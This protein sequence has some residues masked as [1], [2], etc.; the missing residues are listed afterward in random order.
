MSEG[1]AGRIQFLSFHRPALPDGRYSV[2]LT[3]TVWSEAPE[4]SKEIGEQD[5]F[6]HVT[7]GEHPAAQVK[8][9]T[10]TFSI[11]G[12][13][14][15]LDP[16]QIVAVYP[17]EDS[18]GDYADAL[19]HVILGRSTL[20]WEREGQAGREETPWLAV[21]LFDQNEAPTPKVI[22][23]EELYGQ[24]G[25]ASFPTE[26]DMGRN[27]PLEPNEERVTVI[28]VRPELLEKIAP[29]TAELTLLAH[30]RSG[31]VDDR[32]GRVP[33][34]AVVVGN[35]L[36][37]RGRTSVAHL[38][39]VE[40][41]YKNEGLV[42]LDQGK[43]V[44]LV[45]LKSWRYS[46]LDETSYLVTEKAL[47]SLPEPQRSTLRQSNLFNVECVGTKEFKKKAHDILGSDPPGALL[48]AARFKRLTFT[49]LLLK[50]DVGVLRLPALELV[51]LNGTLARR[52]EHYR[53]LGGVPLE[54]QLRGGGVTASWYHGPLISGPNPRASLD[55][56]LG[57]EAAFDSSDH[58]LIY[59]RSLGMLDVSYAA[60][61]ELGRL[62]ALESKPFSL[63]LY[64]WKRT[65]AQALKD[66]RT[67]LE[68][69]PLDGLRGMPDVP[70]LV[71]GWL[72]DLALLKGVP[73]NY[74]V[75]DERLLPRESI[76]FFQVDRL[77]IECLLEG[78]FSIGRVISSDGDH[79]PERPSPDADEV[80]GVVIRSDVVAGWPELQVDGYRD[81]CDPQTRKDPTEQLT[82]LRR[83]RLSDDVLLCLFTPPSPSQT[84]SGPHEGV[85]H[86]VDVHRRP[87]G[88]HFGVS[89]DEAGGCYKRPR[90][91]RTG[92][93]LDQ[94]PVPWKWLDP[95]PASPG[96]PTREW[97][98][99][100]VSGNEPQGLAELILDQVLREGRMSSA[101]FALQMVEGVERV[102]FTTRADRGV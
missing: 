99:L 62:L 88:L 68:H 32:P 79:E 98:V 11:A 49:G 95:V 31:Q 53:L 26:K 81:V 73:F 16:Q 1:E 14:Y 75:P 46:C 34:Q 19:P 76:R 20:P 74:L 28:D 82:P 50:L 12:E 93:E 57:S 71:I 78:A 89:E 33:E 86:T 44:R 9:P 87:E 6:A 56:W 54:H 42:G 65:H 69:L 22:A 35:R 83:D 63:A 91:L 38:V 41:R 61:W 36:G 94:I 15:A 40:R 10:L 45:S 77:W 60:A 90:N 17:P 72:Q 24:H 102:R 64:N 66:A 39:S 100:R 18:S 67:R 101:L 85:V 84:R 43:P 59:D 80:T 21:L 48:T 3:Q 51:G 5:G 13:R 7:R 29:S 55:T 47:A 96:E 4:K 2:Q 25:E 30:V 27:F 92:D 37:I 52:V 70:P 8:L 23:V 58:L 97:R